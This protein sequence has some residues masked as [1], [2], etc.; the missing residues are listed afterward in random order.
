MTN[1]AEPLTRRQAIRIAGAAGILVL[2]G[3]RA[4][5]GAG[6]TATARAATACVLALNLEIGPYFVD[7]KLNRSNVL[8]NADGSAKQAGVPLKLN[9]HL[10]NA[11][12]CAAISGAQVD[13]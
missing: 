6:R 2:A 9:L 4:L 11:K 10:L 12:S 1:V 5:A 13:I 7:V 3:P 8:T